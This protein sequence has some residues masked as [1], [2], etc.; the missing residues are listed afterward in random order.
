MAAGQNGRQGITMRELFERFPDDASAQRWFE[1]RRWGGTPRC[2]HCDATTIAASAKKT[3]P[4]RCQACGK[5]FSVKMGTVMEGSNLGYQT[6]AHA[7][8]LLTTNLKGVASKKLAHDLGVT[9]K[10]A[11]YLSHRIRKA[12][13][14]PSDPM[15]GPVEVDE[16]FVGG[17]EKNKHEYQ[18]KN[19][20]GHED[21]IAV[22]GAKDR[23]TNTVRAEVIGKAEAPRLREFVRRTAVPKATVYSDGHG[24]YM[25][26]DGEFRHKYVQHSAGTYVIEDTHTNGIEAFWSMFRRGYHGTYH[27]MSAKHLQRYVGEF[28]GRHNMRSADTADQ[29]ATVAQGMTGKRLRYRDLIA[30]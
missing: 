19:R 9:Q 30:N 23:A 5:H 15:A 7:I 12:M 26:L 18:R 4:Y 29:M 25:A 21:K 3:M 2:T 28:T 10:S 6:W 22:I 20:G 11:W 16:L 13:E 14:Q 24:A 8:Y 1:E 27:W 17:R